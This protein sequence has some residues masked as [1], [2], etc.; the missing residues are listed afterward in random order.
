M[1]EL[2]ATGNAGAVRLLDQLAL[3]LAAFLFDGLLGSR[4]P[5][6]LPSLLITPQPAEGHNPLQRRQGVQPLPRMAEWKKESRSACCGLNKDRAH[7]ALPPAPPEA[8]P[9]RRDRKSATKKFTV[10]IRIS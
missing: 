3:V 8:T 10:F 2:E 5:S 6:R 7:A 1:A 9:L 4:D